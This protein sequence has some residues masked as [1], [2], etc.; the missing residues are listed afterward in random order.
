MEGNTKNKKKVGI[1]ISTYSQN[2]FLEKCISSLKNLT[3]YKNYRLYL[4]D[5]SGTGKIGE[6]IRKKFRGI[7][8]IINKE[9]LGCSK[10]YNAG[11]KEA[12]RDYNPDYIVLL[13]DDLEFVDPEWLNKII[14]YGEKDKRIGILG[15]RMIYPDRSMQWIAKGGKI[16][17]FMKSGH[18]ERSKDILRT[19]K[20]KEIIGSCY[21]IK[22]R[23]IE[24]I[25]FWDEKFSPYYGEESDYSFR[26]AKKGFYFLYVG[27]TEI[28]HLG[29]SS[30]KKLFNE[31]VWYIKKRNA[32]RLEWLNY[33][34]F[35]IL[36]YSFIHIGSSIA[37]DKPFRKL[38]MLIRAYGKN[39][40]DYKEIKTKRKERNSWSKI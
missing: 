10:S 20:V 5:D 36:K 7:K 40:K 23:V 6:E 22:K 37:G 19:Q 14:F 2:K 15:C 31:K 39:I 16:Y 9:N 3:S 27:D 32:I 4:V 35:S 29:A 34:L 26:A 13:N 18:F 21:I 12:L 1:V 33:D 30:I 8:I 28:I 24:E 25:G 17:S 11:M 38:K